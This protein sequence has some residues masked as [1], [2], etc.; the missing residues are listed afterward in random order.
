MKEVPIHRR[1]DHQA[2]GAPL[3]PGRP[4]VAP[5]APPSRRAASRLRVIVPTP[6]RINERWSMDFVTDSLMNGRRFRSLTIVDDHSRE[7]VAIEAGFPL[8]GE[9]VTRVLTRLG[10]T[11]GLPAVI[12]VDNG[13]EFAGQALDAWAYHKGVKLHFI[14]ET[15]RLDLQAA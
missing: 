6:A 8:T 12:T 7:N 11:R 5:P 13:P 3:P 10:L 15:W 14:I 1:T 4:V 2:G 9:R